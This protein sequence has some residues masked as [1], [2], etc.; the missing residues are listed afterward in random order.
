MQKK[1]QNDNNRIKEYLEQ[2]QLPQKSKSSKSV[3]NRILAIILFI[4]VI[5]LGI[6]MALS[7]VLVSNMVVS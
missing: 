2:D 3:S 4:V 1:T 7:I 5:L 6:C